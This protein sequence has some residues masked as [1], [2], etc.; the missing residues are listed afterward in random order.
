VK[1]REAKTLGRLLTLYLKRNSSLK[2]VSST[3][4]IVGLVNIA[5]LESP[6]SQSCEHDIA[7]GTRS[8]V[9]A[10]NKGEKQL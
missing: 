1:S 8:P 9:A 2:I 5:I 6:I 3:V 4:G 7:F 10:P